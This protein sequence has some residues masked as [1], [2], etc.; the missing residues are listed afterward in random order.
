MRERWETGRETSCGV[1]ERQSARLDQLIR[2][3]GAARPAA[4][5]GLIF[6][7][8]A[9]HALINAA[10]EL[11][12]CDELYGLREDVAHELSRGEAS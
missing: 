7:S 9:G 2:A 10:F 5:L 8:H 1:A 3:A 6:A 4:A 11:F 12:E